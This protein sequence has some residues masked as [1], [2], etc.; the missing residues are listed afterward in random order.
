MRS[1][2]RRARMERNFFPPTDLQNN[3]YNSPLPTPAAGWPRILYVATVSN[4]LWG[5]LG[6]LAAH[7]RSLGWRVDGMARGA[8]DCQRC[9]PMFDRLWEA[10]WSR[11]PLD[12]RNMLV[13]PNF[14]REIVGA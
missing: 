12:V 6:P 4:S 11:N 7:F 10:P 8:T 13:A 9:H 14:I 5:F 2:R 1:A 3:V